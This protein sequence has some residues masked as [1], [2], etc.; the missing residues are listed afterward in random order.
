MNVSS[1]Y[2]RVSELDIW[3]CEIRVAEKKPKTTANNKS[4]D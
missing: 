4:Y 1:N 3:I 2:R